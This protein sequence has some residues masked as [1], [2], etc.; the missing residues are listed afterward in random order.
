MT[1]INL[2]LDI[3]T[4]S[5]KAVELIEKRNGY[6]LRN[7]IK[8]DLPWI[9]KNAEKETITAKLIR[10]FI[11]KYKIN[12]RRVIS[13][14]RGESVIIRRIK[15][16]LMEG[17]QISQAMRWQAEEHIPYSLNQICLDFQVLERNLTGEE[18]EEM[19]VILVGA[20]KETVEK[21]VRLLARTGIFPRII[22]VDA[23]A[24]FNV[25]QLSDSKDND[26]VAL[27]EVGHSTTSIVLLHRGYPFLIRDINWGGSHLTERIKKEL[28]V[29]YQQAQ[30]M[31]ERYGIMGLDD[32]LGVN[33]EMKLANKSKEKADKKLVDRAIR[34]ALDNPLGEIIH[35]FEYYTSER[36]GATI[37]KVILSGGTSCLKNI[38]KFFSEKLGIPV[39]IINPFVSIT[40][41]SAKFQPEYLSKMRSVFAVGLG[42]ALRRVKK[43]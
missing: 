18:G 16:P 24:L 2:G 7:L 29:S 22:D 14:I 6:E 40:A 4:T 36:E 11:R 8:I 34:K 32:E 9:E 20:K 19:S 41:D 33:K 38:D 10:D 35:S 5:I 31:K 3:G 43:I 17:K 23:F 27:L 13:G 12:T 1:K 26:S 37:K 30:Q 21:H 25:F 42:L 15:V 28:R 39:E